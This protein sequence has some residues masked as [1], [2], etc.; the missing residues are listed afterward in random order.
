M[1]K[2]VERGLGLRSAVVAEDLRDRAFEGLRKMLAVGSDEGL[3]LGV[4]LLHVGEALAADGAGV[5]VIFGVL[6][7]AA[8]VHGVAA[9]HE[10]DGEDRGEEELAADGAV[11]LER[12]FE[13]LVLGAGGEGDAGVALV[14]MEVV[15]ANALA[16]SADATAIAVVDVLVRGVVVEVARPAK[17]LCKSDV[18]GA[19]VLANGLD[20][21]ALHAQHLLGCKAVDLVVVDHLVVA[22]PA[23]DKL[24]AAL[25]LQ[26]ATP[27]IML[28]PHHA[29][30][31]IKPRMLHLHLLQLLPLLHGGPHLVALRPRHQHALDLPRLCSRGQGRLA[32]N[33]T[34][35]TPLRVW[36]ERLGGGAE[37]VER[38]AAGGGVEG[39]RPGR[40]LAFAAA[41][42]VSAAH[43]S[44]LGVVLGC[45]LG[46]W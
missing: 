8:G 12:V 28:A 36:G 13:A 1:V 41:C 33:R 32:L 30:L 35:Q 6:V 3:E 37:R 22:K 40:A 10:D 24:P 39:G 26:L 2:V 25:G 14:A 9:A 46:G 17:V 16:N 20:I 31:L 45:W 5:V 43:L 7:E 15:D 19:T 38:E 23:R 11:G 34:D 18:A 21:A 42:S 4:V 29:P 44:F 27:R